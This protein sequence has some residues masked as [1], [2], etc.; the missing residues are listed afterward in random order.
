VVKFPLFLEHH[1]TKS[2]GRLFPRL[3]E[4]YFASWPPAFP[5]AM[6]VETAGGSTSVATAEIRKAEERVRDFE[7]PNGLRS[8]QSDDQRIYRWMFNRLRTKHGVT[9]RGSSA[10]PNLTAGP[11]KKKAAVQTYV[12]HYWESKV[13]QVV[14]DRW[15]PTPETDLFDEADIGEDQ[16][17]WEELT[18]MEKNIPLWFRMQ[19]GRELYEAESDEVKA[20]VDRLRE[21]EKDD[22]DAARISSN[23]FSNDEERREVMKRFDS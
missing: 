15:A 11:P 7:F 1:D 23:I 8:N 9:G 16:V 21:Q 22:A 5:T 20:K 18:P 6:E 19:I 10:H 17:A 2:L 12:K 3:Y 4:E 13:R 14:I